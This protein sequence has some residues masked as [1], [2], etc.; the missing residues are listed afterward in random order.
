MVLSRG[1]IGVVVVAITVVIG[2]AILSNFQDNFTSG[3]AEYNA[4]E[5]A[6][7]GLSEFPTWFTTIVIIIVA[8]FILGLVML[9]GRTRGGL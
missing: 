8:V 4:T 9:L 1:A 7:E 6:I 2:L 5:D 3:T